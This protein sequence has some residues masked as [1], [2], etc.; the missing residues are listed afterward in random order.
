MV[1]ETPSL[2]E[3][4]A[5]YDAAMRFHGLQPWTWLYEDQVFGVVNPEN[6]EVGYCSVMGNLGQH[7]ALAVYLGDEG[8]GSFLNMRD[9]EGGPDMLEVFFRQKALQVSFED[10]KMLTRE[11]HQVIRRLGLKFRGRQAWPLFRD[12]TPGY[13]PWYLTASQARFLTLALEQTIE[14]STRFRDCPEE[15]PTVDEEE[16][17][18][19][20]VSQ[21]GPAGLIWKDE[22]RPLPTGIPGP[23]LACFW[24]AEKEEALRRKGRK[25][26]RQGALEIDYFYL[27]E[28]ARDRPGERPFHPQML[29]AADHGSGIILTQNLFAPGDLGNALVEMLQ[30]LLLQY[31]DAWPRQIGVRRR[32]LALVL[33]RLVGPLGIEVLEVEELPAIA[34]YRQTLAEWRGWKF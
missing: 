14:V 21:P 33:A 32:E 13:M 16:D 2:E 6:G 19:V 11:D 5:L 15:L 25:I 3:W 1:E 8:F 28:A 23:K 34:L 30:D 10:R 31:L 22:Q 18:L 26:G 7:L 12:I 20:R 9:A 27:P 24:D 17:L 29:L 4:R